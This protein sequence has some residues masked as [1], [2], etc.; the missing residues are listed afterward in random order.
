MA[1]PLPTITVLGQAYTVDVH[2][3]LV[4]NVEYASEVC[5]FDDFYETIVEAART[6]KSERDDA[7][8]AEAHEI[9]QVFIP[10]ML[11]SPEPDGPMPS[12]APVDERGNCPEPA[13]QKK[14]QRG[15]D[16]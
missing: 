14:R 2:L 10:F 9:L 4:Q 12:H 3:R 15:R 5:S 16:R 6:A 11:T 1:D 8:L 7:R 13:R